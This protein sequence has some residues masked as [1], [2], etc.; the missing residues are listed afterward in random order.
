MS[1]NQNCEYFDSAVAAQLKEYYQSHDFTGH[2]VG[3]DAS[4]STTERDR[5]FAKAKK[6]CAFAWIDQLSAIGVKY[7]QKNY[8]ERYPL[9]CLSDA[10]GDYIAG[11][12]ADIMSEPKKFDAVL[13]VF[14]AQLQPVLNAGFT[15]LAN[16]LKK[17]VEELTEEEIHTVVDAAA[18][19][20]MESMI[21]ALALAQQVPEIAGVARKHASH[22]DF[23][24]SVAVNHDKIDFDR[25]WNHTRTKLG[26]PLSLDELATSDPSALEEGHSMFET[27]DEEYD[28]L[29][30][31]FLDTMNRT[32]REIYL[33]RK[34]GLTQA[35][36]AERL[37]YK[38]HSAVTKRME[39]MRKALID[40][41]ADFDN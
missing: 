30:N 17:S 28:R 24:K 11:Q 35:E 26:A 21:Q 27:N 15:S 36:I 37:G 25:K 40:F 3:Y 8:S 20:Y 31:Q 29:E 32:D 13:D 7:R 1:N 19:M 6:I 5:I 2:I 10:N 23:N 33:M 9:R 12:V 39:K 18:Q 14:F 41:C 38:T 16:S 22:S 34:Q 4:N